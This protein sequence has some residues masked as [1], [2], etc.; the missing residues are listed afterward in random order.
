MNRT[1]MMIVLMV[2]S[3]FVL[4]YLGP[5]WSPLVS[6]FLVGGFG[7]RSCSR[8]FIGGAVAMIILWVGYAVFIDISDSTGLTNRVGAIFINSIPALKSISGTVLIYS[9]LT[10]IAILLGG[11]STISGAIFGSLFKR[12][13]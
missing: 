10:V 12:G 5:W 11:L 1:L 13:K 7:F 4:A 3:G 6:C 8:A 9:L 2:I